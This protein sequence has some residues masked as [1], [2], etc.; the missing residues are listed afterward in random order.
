MLW[1]RW[2][3]E[4][5]RCCRRDQIDGRRQSSLIVA[6]VITIV[7]RTTGIHLLMTH[8]RIL[9]RVLAPSTSIVNRRTTLTLRWTLLWRRWLVVL[10][11][12][13]RR[14]WACGE[15]CVRIIFTTRRA[16]PHTFPDDWIDMAPF[17]MQ[18]C[19]FDFHCRR[20][21]S[22]SRQDCIGHTNAAVLLL[23]AHRLFASRKH[24]S[25]DRTRKKA[26]SSCLL[27]GRPSVRKRSKAF[28]TI[29]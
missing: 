23:L 2:R 28:Q 9:R 19:R 29:P 1:G 17:L 14:L 8:M 27:P 12:M 16:T 25:A 11:W 6:V 13:H 15:G 21:L 22:P 4:K 5:H 3:L 18:I 24:Q 7:S 20:Q 26:A 10:R